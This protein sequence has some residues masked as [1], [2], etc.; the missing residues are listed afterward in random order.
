MPKT[1][2]KIKSLDMLGDV[3][4]QL[5]E[6]GKSVVLCHGTFDLIHTGHIRHLQEAKRQ[7]DSLFVTITAD[8][9]VN[10][11]P[12]RP[13]FSETLR[14]E[15][16]SALSCVDYVGIVPFESAEEPIL[17]IKPNLYVKGNEY[18]NAADDV[19]GKIIK[20]KQLVEKFNG[21]IYFTD[22]ITFSS[23]SLLNEHFGVFPPETK[24]YLNKFKQKY[25]SEEIIGMLRSLEDLNVLVVGDAIVDEY[26]YVESLGQS[27]KGD[28]LSYKF[29]SK[30]QFAG[31]SLAIANHIAG[32]VKEVT[33]VTGLGKEESH[34]EFI[35]SK[36]EK[37]VLPEFFYFK[38]APT[39]VKRRYVNMML[40]K[41]FE[42]YFYNDKF[43]SEHIDKD[44]CVWLEKNTE[45]FD[46]V[47]V[48]DFGNGFIFEGMIQKI[49]KHARFLAV[50][51]QVNSGN[52]GYHTINRYPRADFVS[53]NTPEVRIA[54]HDRYGSVENLAKRII[55]QLG[56]KYL[57]VTLGANGAIL[58]NKSPEK[59]YKTP[60]LST[61]V[62]DR[63]GAGDSF[64][65][66][67]GL[68]LGKGLDSDIA[69]FVGGAA[70]A[71][72]VQVVCNRDPI[73]PVNLY[74]YIQT[75]LKS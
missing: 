47:V 55:G 7:G 6:E 26:H 49:C 70:A 32:F 58:L 34:E 29:N 4:R 40:S 66:L 69:L 52:R 45:K 75:L 57:A 38:D 19:T 63:I 41:L 21:K 67:A 31:G 37:N 20:E 61:K 72:D 33:L 16:L 13:V 24:N 1:R 71:L 23:S 44:I 64:L 28:N 9:Y 65:S 36:L 14:A 54:T 3:S 18:E 68:C 10:K 42:V 51:T 35:R 8:K 46:V 15:N 27:A 56:A 22:D 60:A 2:E 48:P 50:N 43:H 11:G 30:E 62:L 17:R 73:T 5:V 39:I 25:S 12:G 74:K 59:I 53:L